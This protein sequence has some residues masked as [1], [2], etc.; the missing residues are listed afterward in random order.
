MDEIK[1]CIIQTFG[2]L[3]TKLTEFDLEQIMNTKMITTNR[4]EELVKQQGKEE[5][6][7]EEDDNDDYIKVTSLFSRVSPT[8]PQGEGMVDIKPEVSE[9]DIVNRSIALKNADHLSSQ[10][11]V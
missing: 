8:T 5:S 3:R 11:S 9:E 2:E 1:A 10:K 7:S 4:A 6:E